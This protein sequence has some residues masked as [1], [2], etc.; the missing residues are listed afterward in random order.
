[1]PA[2]V[3]TSRARSPRLTGLLALLLLALGPAAAR[4]H[5]PSAWGGLFRSRDAGATWFPANQGRFVSGAIALAISPTDVTHLLLATDTGLLRSRNAGRDW[6][7][8][9]PTVLLGAVLAAAFDRD[10]LRSLASTALGIYRTDDGVA[11]RQVRAPDGLAPA[12]AIVPGGAAGRVY[13]AGFNGLARSEDW[14]GSWESA[15]EG[16]PE[17]PVTS[18]TVVPGSPDAV[19]AVAGGRL[20]ASADAGRTW[21]PRDSGLPAG[22]V[23]AVA[24]DPREA[25]RLWAAGADRLFDSEDAGT[26]WRPVG[27]PLVEPSTTVRGIAVSVSRTAIVLATDRGLY[28]SVDRGGRWELLAENLPVHLEAGLLV[29]DPADPATLYAGFALTPYTEMWR[30]AAEGGNLLGRLD[31]VSLAGG[32]VFLI[33]LGLGS[34][35]LLRRLARYYRAPAP[36]KPGGRVGETAR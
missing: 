19:Y 14:G 4:A 26:N 25:R 5:D 32:V 16:L 23:D 3:P 15:A 9:A 35:M 27:R 11:W 17:T 7:V 31:W 18:L 8:E 12:R 36:L 1:M 30:L 34:A 21:Q 29:R 28:R 13:V 20:M 6:T 10:G 22:A 2:P 33:V 24:L